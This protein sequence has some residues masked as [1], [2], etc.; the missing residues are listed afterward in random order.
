MLVKL[1]IDSQYCM[2]V[3]GMTNNC[4][5]WMSIGTG[6]VVD[7]GLRIK[8]IVGGGVVYWEDW[9]KWESILCK[10]ELKFEIKMH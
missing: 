7:V 1:L 3:E 2:I 6:G 10:W 4:G 8:F 9:D 5:N